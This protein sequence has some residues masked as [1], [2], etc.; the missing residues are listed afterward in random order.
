MDIRSLRYFIAV[1][2]ERSLSAAAKRCF[3]A[4]PS[5]S[6]TLAQLEGDLGTQLFVRHSK[7]VIPTDSGA[8]LYPHACRMVNEMNAMR[9]MFVDSH[10]P[11][12]VSIALTP[13]LSGAL[14]SQVL[15]TL[16]DEIPG[17]TFSLVDASEEADLRF[18]CDSFVTDNDVFYQLWEDNYVIAMI[19]DH[20]LTE[21]ASLSIKQID[22]LAFISRRPCDIQE[23]WNYLLQ[24]QGISMDIRAQVKTEEYALDLVAAGLGISLIPEHSLRGRQDVTIRPINDVALKRVVG[25][26]HN[27]GINLP[28]H[29]INTILSMKPLMNNKTAAI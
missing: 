22:K 2:E 25:I 5:I 18:T 11:L 1:F 19:N 26:A 16:L 14:V 29:L 17:L 6:T 10:A 13:F 8:Q 9:S 7:G 15:K 4:Q 3:V 23:S 21:F 20:W 28:A 24:K 27:K 12:E